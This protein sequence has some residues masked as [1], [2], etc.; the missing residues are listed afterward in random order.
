MLILRGSPALSQFRLQ[1][2]LQDL[3]A[4]GLPVRAISAEFVHIVELTAELAERESAVLEKLLTYGPRRAAA[5]VT[6]L[7]QVVA[8]RP[9]TISPWS[10]KAT[11]IAHICGLAGVKRIERVI[12]YSIDLG[13]ASHLKSEIS[14]L[15]SGLRATLA[16]RLHD[17]MTQVVF[18]DLA[19]CDALFRHETPRAMASVP[20][21]A[22]GRAALVAA[23]RALGLALAEDEIDY[24]VKAFTALGRDPNDIELMMF[25]QANSEHCRH[26]IF[27]AT[28]EIDG[29]ARDRSL[30]QM[31]K[32]TYQLHPAGILSAYK[33]NAAV[34]AGTRGG[35]F[36]V[37]P[38]TGEYAA[39]DE[40]IHVL[41][42]VET[43]NHPTAI[44]PFPGAA[45]GSGG[46][47]RDEGATGR[48]SKPK[49]GLTGFTVSNLKLPSAIQP[50]EKEN[51][52]P[53]RIVSA[54]DIMIEGPLGGAAFNNEFGRPAINGYFRT[55][56]A[57]VPAAT[58]AA[59]QGSQFMVHGSEAKKDLTT[60]P[61]A[62]V[63]DPGAGLSEAGY[64]KSVTSV[65]KNPAFATELRGYHKPIMLAGGLGN[66]RADH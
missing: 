31:I 46:E 28:W 29:A 63:A 53:G 23:D 35:R 15:K 27:N 7:I 41:C 13:G 24:L 42:K 38:Q 52:K 3:A 10:S 55:F 12:A 11:D 66:I 8:P 17:R 22:Q 57:A 45:T 60:K 9:G 65:L 37:D 50:W 2:L 14:D 26:K 43:H 64:N 58:T 33:D 30:F 20:V 16:A 36:Y 32:N 4:A 54:L 1:K 48:G 5:A 19:A 34:L 49:A 47:I 25:A 18:S 51:G 44:S 59:V 61:V 40:D 6:G 39:H 62:G 56:E 21:L